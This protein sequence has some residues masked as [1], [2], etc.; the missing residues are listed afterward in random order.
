VCLALRISSVTNQHLQ[1]VE[2]NEKLAVI[3]RLESNINQQLIKVEKNKQS[4]LASAFC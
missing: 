1:N 2:E 3:R 4:I